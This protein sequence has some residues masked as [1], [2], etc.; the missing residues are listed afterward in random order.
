[1]RA[2]LAKLAA[3]SSRLRAGVKTAGVVG[4]A[5]KATLGAIRHPL[6]TT[7]R[8]VTGFA[9]HHPVGAAATA[10]TAALGTASG[11]GAARKTR[12]GFDPN[13]QR[14]MLGGGPPVPPGVE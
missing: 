10:G 9:Y 4:G 1:M 6:R 14:Q 2:R 13:V 12:A 3:T 8:A 7:G 5:V 11:V